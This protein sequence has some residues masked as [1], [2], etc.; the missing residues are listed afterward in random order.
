MVIFFS[1]FI[2]YVVC[3]I[4][5]YAAMAGLYNDGDVKA[6]PMPK[7]R[8]VYYLLS[9]TWGLPMNIVGAIVALVL[10]IAGRRAEKYGWNYMFRL[11]INFGLELG[12]FFLA[13]KNA[14]DHTKKH[15]LGHSIQNVYLGPFT[16]GVVSA[17]SAVRF[18]F[19][20]IKRKLGK[21]NTTTYDS[22]WFEG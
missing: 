18:W 15:E 6:L 19:R 21:K 3:C 13:P 7:S 2:P 5:L 11:P 9:F 8:F 17:P 10:T 1:I 22:I 12:I 4:A 20:E 14:S 16:V